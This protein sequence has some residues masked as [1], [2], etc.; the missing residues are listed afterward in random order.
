MPILVDGHNLIGQMSDISLEDPDDE[1][2]LV[3][4]LR[5]YRARTGKSITVIFD[6]GEFYSPPSTLSSAGVRVRFAPLGSSAD[7]LLQK[8]IRRA[9]NPRGLKVVSS[10]RA[11]VQAA[12]ERGAQAISASD[13]AAELSQL[14][15]V[16]DPPERKLSP[17]EVAEWL[18]IFGREDKRQRRS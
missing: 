2:Q 14:G 3:Q 9:A 10:D 12:R 17:E 11:V 4:R 18:K 7:V 5:A 16:R 6:N 13:F 8:Y 15:V 1:A